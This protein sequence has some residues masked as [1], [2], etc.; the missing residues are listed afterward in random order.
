MEAPDSL[1][2][3]KIGNMVPQ[4]GSEGVVGDVKDSEVV[5]DV[6][7]ENGRKR[8]GDRKDVEGLGGKEDVAAVLSNSKGRPLQR[9]AERDWCNSCLS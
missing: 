6:E 8:K 7:E 9:D 2:A 5:V 1:G 4:V 3:W